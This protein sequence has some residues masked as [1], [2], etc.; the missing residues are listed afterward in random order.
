M[1]R[2]WRLVALLVCVALVSACV[3]DGAPT[4]EEPQPVVRPWEFGAAME[5]YGPFPRPDLGTFGE[6]V[7]HGWVTMIAVSYTHLTL[8]TIYSV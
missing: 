6:P 7:I 4:S 8:P 3:D 1:Q 5:R 2:G